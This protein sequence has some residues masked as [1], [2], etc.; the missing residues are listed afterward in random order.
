M[1]ARAIVFPGSFGDTSLPRIGV[2][3]SQPLAGALYDWAVDGLS[4]GPLSQ[5]GS[6]V[7]GTL[8]SAAGGS[9]TV[10]GTGANAV[11]KFNGTTD[12]AQSAFTLTGAHTVV[13]V[14]R[15]VSPADNNQVH[16]GLSGSG[17]G[18]VGIG[19]G[20]T[21]VRG[22]GGT[23]FILPNPAIAP[24]TNWHISLLSVDGA[25]SVFRHDSA[26]VVGTLDAGTRDGITLGFAA[27]SAPQRTAIEYKRVA[28]LKGGTS[29]WQRNALIAQLKQQYGI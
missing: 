27:G 14:H 12:R 25:N 28:I 4:A 18:S 22:A 3:Y 2:V 23:K 24:D 29:S 1:T 11:V 16:Y 26:E 6:N 17:V 9:P 15:F 10:V 8:M 5:W 19:G 7:D 13:T 20:G 21:A